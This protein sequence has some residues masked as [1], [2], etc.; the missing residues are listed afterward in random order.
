MSLPI[1]PM[2]PM[3][4]GTD[5][6]FRWGTSVQFYDSGASQ[7]NS[8]FLRP[9]IDYNMPLSNI[10]EIKQTSLNYF[11]NVLTRGPTIPF[12]MKDPYLFRVQSVLA[13]RSGYASG[14]GT[15][16][17]Y[18]LNSWFIRADTTTIG[19]L[20]SATSG[21]VRLGVEYNYDQDTGVFTVNTKLVSDVWGA[22]S[23][24]HFQKVRFVN[25][26]REQSPIW[27]IFGAQLEMRGII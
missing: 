26:Y 27:N 3:P 17:L 23:I 8:P 22:R 2:S 12:L 15:L 1:F 5:R 25:D 19:S 11:I 21:Y 24:E 20:F 14:S 18:D 9:L 4:G 13:V 6:T 7:G 16:N 10:N